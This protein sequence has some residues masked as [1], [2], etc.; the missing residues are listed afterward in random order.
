R[1]HTVRRAVPGP[2][3]L[4]PRAPAA[5]GP[6]TARRARPERYG[7]IPG[8]P[9][10]RSLG[11]PVPHAGIAAARGR[12]PPHLQ[13]LG[14]PR[15]HI[16]VE[17][18]PL[19]SAPGRHPVVDRSKLLPRSGIGVSDSHLIIAPPGNPVIR[20]DARLLDRIELIGRSPRGAIAMAGAAVVGV[21]A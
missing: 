10:R 16:L 7:A 5:G 21:V 3:D 14:R 17:V 2:L 12:G 8:R 11:S 19:A 1:A 13:A 4:V 6:S 20:L 18:D 9:Y 15:H